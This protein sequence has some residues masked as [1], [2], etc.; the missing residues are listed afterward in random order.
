MAEELTKQWGKFTLREDDNPGIVIK[1]QAFVPL[2][3]RGQACMV[4][5]L[6]A[7]RTINKEILKTP[8]IWE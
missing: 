2:V 8:M 6:L 4:G 5:R 7:E 3:Q 1:E